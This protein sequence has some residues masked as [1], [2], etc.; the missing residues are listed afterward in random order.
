VGQQTPIV[1]IGT[2]Q[3]DRYVV[4]D[5]Y[6]RIAA[7]Q[8]LGRDTVEAV[9]WPMGEAEALLLDRS[10][11]LTEQ[12]TP[13]EQGWLIGRVGAALP[14]WAGGVGTAVWPQCE[15]GIAAP[16][17]GGTSAGI[18][19]ATSPWRENLGA[20]GDEV[21]WCRRRASFSSWQDLNQ[22][23]REWCD[24]VNS[25]YKKHIRAV[26]GELFAAER[27]H[28]KP[29]PAWIPEVYRL[30]HRIVDVEGYVAP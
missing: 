12:E 19:P 4:I 15:L 5:G 17:T 6:K 28:L 30:H 11:R 13:L 7:L 18:D 9:V 25:T 27:L 29:P 22:Q 14:L 26:P 3:P 8:Q 20:R 2:D 23:A 21:F 16:G 1:V 10:L 24:N